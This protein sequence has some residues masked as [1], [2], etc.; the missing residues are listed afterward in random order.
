MKPKGRDDIAWLVDEQ[1]ALRRVATLVAGAPDPL[2]VFEMVTREA[3]QL[4]DIPVLTLMRYEPD[5]T[6][7]VLAEASVSPFRVGA[8]IVL[9]G[10]R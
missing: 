10:P 6:V 3:S 4:L 9:D 7:T 5:G 2:S 1:A 8:N